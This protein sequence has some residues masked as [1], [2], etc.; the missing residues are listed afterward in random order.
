MW[1]FLAGV[2]SHLDRITE[3]TCRFGLTTFL[4][5]NQNKFNKILD[6]CD[7]I[8]LDSGAYS[9]QRGKSVDMDT[10]CEQYADF[11][12]TNNNNPK[13]V[14][15]FEMDVDNIV[16]YQKVLE[17][18]EKLE[19]YTNKLIPVWHSN[20]GINEFIEMCKKY[21]GRR[22]AV[23]A[24]G[25]DIEISQYNKFI[26]MAHKYGCKIHILGMTSW[27]TIENLNLGKEDS[28]DS[29]SWIMQGAFGGMSVFE[30]DKL[31]NFSDC[32]GNLPNVPATNY[33]C[34]CYLAH[35]RLQLKYENI[36]QSV[37]V[38]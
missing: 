28:V 15:F 18:R 26:N 35:K 8:L 20:R 14:G 27:Q 3:G 24:L 36:D 6:K 2:E 13:I 31:Y 21:R 4:G 34:I 17:W 37:E 10:Y 16:G 7:H 30:N 1:Y 19:K 11:I 9:L 32:T 38:K 23:T 29:T 33:V 22:V 12:K 25:E 5:M